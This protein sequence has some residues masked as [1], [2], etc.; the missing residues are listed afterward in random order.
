MAPAQLTSDRG[1]R[2]GPGSRSRDN[3]YPMIMLKIQ[4]SVDNAEIIVYRMGSLIAKPL[5]SSE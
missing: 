2:S 1:A 5:Q 4:H 3:Y